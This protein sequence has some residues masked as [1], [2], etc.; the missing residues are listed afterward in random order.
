MPNLVRRPTL[1]A[2]CPVKEEVFYNVFTDG[3]SSPTPYRTGCLR[4]AY[5]APGRHLPPV[6][7]VPHAESNEHGA[8]DVAPMSLHKSMFRSSGRSVDEPSGPA[9]GIA[10]LPQTQTEHGEQ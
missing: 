1:L 4:V 6:N 7:S 5:T 9:G 2:L 3:S 8:I 10:S